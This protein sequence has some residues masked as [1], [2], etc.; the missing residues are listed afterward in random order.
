MCY[1][2]IS[3]CYVGTYFAD[4][5]IEQLL[6]YMQNFIVIT[7]LGFGWEENE[8]SMAFRLWLKKKKGLSE[9]GPWGPGKDMW[10]NFREHSRY[11]FNQWETTLH[12]NVVSHWLSPY[13]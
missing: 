8:I 10:H 9:T 1:S 13:L 11:G 2:S 3:G 12:Y 4:V 6:Y 7:E 5:A